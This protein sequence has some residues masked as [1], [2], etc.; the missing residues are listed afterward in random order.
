VSFILGSGIN[1]QTVDSFWKD[2]SGEN[3]GFSR[4]GVGWGGKTYARIM[5]LSP[6]ADLIPGAHYSVVLK[7]DATGTGDK[8]WKIDYATEFQVAC[9]AENPND[10]PDLGEFPQ[11][12]IDG[13]EAFK[14]E[15]PSP[16]PIVEEEVPDNSGCSNLRGNLT[17]LLCLVV[18]MGAVRR[19]AKPLHTPINKDLFPK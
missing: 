18:L 2:S 14:S 8:I 16:D 7:S 17:P 15:W 1:H 10:C 13:H 4:A 19:N 11:P 12:K 9:G 5:K 3:V 6:K